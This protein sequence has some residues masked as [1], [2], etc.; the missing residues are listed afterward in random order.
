MA[1]KRPARAGKRK[2]QAKRRHHR[3]KARAARLEAVRR[4]AATLLGNGDSEFRRQQI[5]SSNARA[6]AVRQ[7]QRPSLPRFAAL[8]RPVLPLSPREAELAGKTRGGRP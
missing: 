1:A 2:T 3:L 6:P 5:V 4:V 7:P 8:E